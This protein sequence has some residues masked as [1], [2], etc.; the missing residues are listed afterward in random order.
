MLAPAAPLRPGRYAFVSTHEGMFGG[1]DFSYL[2][3]VPASAATTPIASNPNGHAPAV[4]GDLF[5]VA[6][7][8]VAFLFAFLLLRS[9][10][11]QAGRAEGVLGGGVPALRGRGLGRGDRAADGWTPGLFRA[12]YLCG[13]V[14]TVAYLGAGSAWLKLPRRAAATSCSAAS[15][16][17]PPP[18]P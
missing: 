7:A 17:R 13:G 18:R 15:S 10:I 16:S 3:V 8:L 4:A 2:R 9:L 12:Y 14:L 5:P 6:A 1:Q 11:A